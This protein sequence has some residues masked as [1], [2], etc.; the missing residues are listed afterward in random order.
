[1]ACLGEGLRFPSASS[2]NNKYTFILTWL[3]VMF[4]AGYDI[5][6]G[7]SV[8]VQL[9]RIG[10]SWHVVEML[11]SLA[12]S[13][14]HT[15]PYHVRSFRRHSLVHSDARCWRIA[16]AQSC[17]VRTRLQLHRLLPSAIS[18]RHHQ[19]HHHH[20]HQPLDFREV[21]YGRH[22]FTFQP[23]AAELSNSDVAMVPAAV[24]RQGINSATVS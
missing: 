17:S 5:E 11:T 3:I 23:P 19:H 1:M 13:A 18:H 20:H 15:T 4:T 21:V 16:R 24:R 8:V 6:S 22:I 12:A 2:L 10:L 14:R 9:A 7:R